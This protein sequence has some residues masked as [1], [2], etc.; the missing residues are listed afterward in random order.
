MGRL[1]RGALYGVGVRTGVWVSIFLVHHHLPV[2]VSAILQM[3]EYLEGVATFLD[4]WYIAC[5]PPNGMYWLVIVWVRGIMRLRGQLYKSAI[6]PV[7]QC[8]DLQ[9]LSCAVS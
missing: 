1:E 7:P 8:N 3:L 2:K 6:L 5:I 4:S 9:H